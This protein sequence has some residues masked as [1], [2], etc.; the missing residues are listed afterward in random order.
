MK[1][2]IGWFVSNPVAA[3]LL[4]MILIVGGLI[5]V[6]QIRQEE[7]PPIDLDIVTV[8][9]PYLGAAPEEVENGVSLRIEEAMEGIQGIYR[10]TSTASEGAG[11]VVLE[12]ET[13]ANRIQTANEIKSQIDAIS[14]FP[15]ETERP[16]VS[17]LTTLNDG[18][19]IAINGDA[20]ERTLKELALEIRDD[21]AAMEGISSVN[22][23]YV[24]PDEISIEVSE[25]TLRR[26]GLTFD[27]VAECRAADIAGHA[28]RIDQV[29]R[30]RD[31]APDPGT[32]LY[33]R[34]L[35]RHRCRLQGGR[36][37][38][39]SGRDRND[40]RRI[41]GGRYPGAIRRQARGHRQGQS[42]GRRRH[43]RD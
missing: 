37:E 6:F 26:M 40:H 2:I 18:L 8:S 33:R 43:R 42:G 20:D 27:Q 12:L 29:G 1:R 17:L 35:S 25:Q 9:V 23:A 24:R 38:S 7:M 30:R 39:L 13:N 21:I 10:M 32:S 34:G 3:N 28:R 5:S 31:P 19:E 16:V 36:H 14:T 4:M 41:S 15:R 22:A 11:S